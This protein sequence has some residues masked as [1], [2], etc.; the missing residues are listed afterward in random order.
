MAVLSRR[1]L[2]GTS[3]A[4]M[5]A[6]MLP[7]LLLSQAR[8]ASAQPAAGT[9]TAFTGTFNPQFADWCADRA[10]FVH[11]KVRTGQATGA[12]LQHMSQVLRGFARHLQDTGVDAVFRTL[13][14]KFVFTGN[15]SPV[16]VN[17]ALSVCSKHSPGIKA[18]DLAPLQFKTAAADHARSVMAAGGIS[19]F[20]QTAADLFS[21]CGKQLG[22][23]T[24]MS[25]FHQQRAQ[26]SSLL[27]PALYVPGDAHGAMASG[28][29]LDMSHTEGQL[30]HVDLGGLCKKA[31]CFIIAKYG[32]DY[33]AGLI[34]PFIEENIAG[35]VGGVCA[36]TEVAEVI[37][38]VVTAGLGVFATPVGIA[39]CMAMAGA[40]GYLTAGGAAAL[41]NVVTNALAFTLSASGC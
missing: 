33:L 21:I 15:V 31:I 10:A 41:S 23:N 7:T 4:A 32:I 20:Y 6:S 30:L 14:P 28:I 19:T 17:S 34:V 25:A 24:T 38:T 18:D 37:A 13:A 11:S 1:E 36:A 22:T 16:V 2:I 8:A 39:I 26:R 12:H 35:W 9:G 27:Q 40:A 29:V 5:S 3:A